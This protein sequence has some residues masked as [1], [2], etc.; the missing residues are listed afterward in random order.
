MASREP[1]F[2]KYSPSYAAST[3]K[4][5]PSKVEGFLFDM[6]ATYAIAKYNGRFLGAFKSGEGGGGAKCVEPH[7]EDHALAALS[8]AATTILGQMV[9]D[10]TLKVSKS[11]CRR[12]TQTILT[13]RKNHPKL[14]IRIKVLGL[15]LGDGAAKAVHD[16]ARLQ[17]AEIPVMLWDVR[18]SYESKT[19][20]RHGPK[21]RELKEFLDLGGGH[22]DEIEKRRV[23]QDQISDDGFKYDVR[24]SVKDDYRAAFAAEGMSEEVRRRIMV[25]ALQNDLARVGSDIDGLLLRKAGVEANILKAQKWVSDRHGPGGRAVVSMNDSRVVQGGKNNYNALLDERDRLKEVLEALGREKEEH[26]AALKNLGQ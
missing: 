8:D 16:V 9:G 1:L 21:A 7:A 14:R 25:S 26:E 4:V 18:S 24:W 10:F 23:R 11:P 17:A 6:Q 3:Y 2:S 22:F 13:L 5:T 15:Y 20:S 12:C 19:E